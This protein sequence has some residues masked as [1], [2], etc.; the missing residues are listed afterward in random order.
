MTGGTSVTLNRP[1]PAGEGT[2]FSNKAWAGFLQLSREVKLFEGFDVDM[3]KNIKFWED[4]YNSSAPQSIED[5]PGKWGELSVLH[6]SIVMRLLRP[7]KVV[8]MIQKL[9]TEEEEMGQY[10][11]IPPSF[12]MAEIV[13]D[14]INNTPIIIVLSPGADPMVDIMEVKTKLK[15]EMVAMSL[16]RGQA[17]IAIETIKQA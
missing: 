14:S 9:I 5:W 1:N 13:A 16:G 11:I 8:I 10:F 15:Q 2:W 12:D 4:M 17:G 7:D 6:K 3:E